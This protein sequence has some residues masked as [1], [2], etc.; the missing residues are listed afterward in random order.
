MMAV[1]TVAHR[2]ASMPHR[3]FV[4]IVV[5][6]MVFGLTNLGSL[7]HR[8]TKDEL[9]AVPHGEVSNFGHGAGVV[10]GGNLSNVTLSDRIVFDGGVMGKMVLGFPTPFDHVSSSDP[11]HQVTFDEVSQNPQLWFES[12][13]PKAECDESSAISISGYTVSVVIGGYSTSLSSG[14]GA[15]YAWKG[16]PDVC[17]GVMASYVYR[18]KRSRW[19]LLVGYSMPW[20]VGAS[21]FLS[22]G[23]LCATICGHVVD[24][25]VSNILGFC[26][27]GIS[28]SLHRPDG[29]TLR[30]WF[31]ILCLFSMVSGGG[32]V[33]CTT[34]FDQIS[35]C[36]GGADCPLLKGTA[37]NAAAI[38]A[39]GMA[40][41]T[42]SQLLPFSYV[43]HLSSD[44]LRSLQAIAR[45]PSGAAPVDL[46]SLDAQ[47]LVDAYQQGRA[48]L[49]AIR[50]EIGKRVADPA[51]NASTVTRLQ[52]ISSIF[53]DAPLTSTGREIEGCQT[54]GGLSFCLAVASHIVRSEKSTYSV[55]TGAQASSS[56]DGSRRGGT[57]SRLG[58]KQPTSLAL[59]AE[60]LHVWQSILHALGLSNALV[61]TQFLQEVVFDAMSQLFFTWQQSYCLLLIY[62]EAIESHPTQYNLANVF[63]AGS[64][65]T[66]CKAARERASRLFKGPPDLEDKDGGKPVKWNGKDTPNA[67]SVC[68]TFN[69][70]SSATHPA[71]SLSPD[72]TCKF[73][74]CCNQFVT[75]KGKGGICEGAHARVGCDN[76]GKCDKPAD[77]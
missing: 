54:V 31:F 9:D 17:W 22:I 6:A 60:L 20:C 5:F 64:Q 14:I 25:V 29:G 63:G 70:G 46:S 74:H 66:R 33:T 21:C 4:P 57:S 30:R 3:A 2:G 18:I 40:V 19:H 41:L 73:R 23:R 69:L 26:R 47:G 68:Y 49:D 51:T 43:R 32:A 27:F 28:T 52:A 76:P 16:C 10:V 72:G 55:G 13:G 38:A 44:V 58:I 56:S 62:I 36:T 12:V 11:V 7:S 61:T 59:F 35:G 53:K 48:D 8:V 67:K 42:V 75:G 37:A 77:A 45:A 15:S 24:S 1:C 65:D 34:C 71:K 39:S 50:G